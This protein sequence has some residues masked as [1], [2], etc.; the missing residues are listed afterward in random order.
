MK[1]KTGS[2]F[3]E[4]GLRTVC[5]FA[6][7]S[8]PVGM[9][10]KASGLDWDPARTWVF[11]V[12][13][14]EWKDPDWLQFPKQDRSDESLIKAMRT[15]GVP[16]DQL[17]FLEDRQATRETITSSLTSLLRRTGP[18]DSLIFY[19]TGHGVLDPSGS[20]YMVPYDGEEIDSLLPV[21]A[22][23]QVIQRDFRGDRVLL[24]GDFCHSGAM[25]DAARAQ[26]GPIQYLAFA[27]STVGYTSTEAWT[28]TD[29]MT[30]VFRGDAGADRDGDGLITAGEIAEFVRGEMSFG[31]SQV[32]DFGA[33]NPGL[34]S[35]KIA[36]STGVRDPDIGTHL[37]VDFGG[38]D[39]P[40]RIVEHR[41]DKTLVHWYAEWDSTELPGPDTWI[42]TKRI[43]PYRLPPL[44]PGTPV[45]AVWNTVWLPA[46]VI[47]S[48]N[49]V[50]RTRDVITGVE[51]WLPPE[52]IRR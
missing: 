45:F 32:S 1:V 2:F 8:G 35:W 52:W 28:F 26:H 17:V 12:G 16:A 36:R 19:F 44:A 14:V 25:A 43:E 39:W 13:L 21:S 22:L 9:A 41:G 38:N 40:G 29:A 3:A 47:E 7:F 6:L 18:G 24:L 31:D 34:A 23:P 37:F 15:W 48:G 30:S 5:L 10:A 27:S 20:A 11:G 4:I 42:A 51:R 33:S 46:V 50:Y 49:E